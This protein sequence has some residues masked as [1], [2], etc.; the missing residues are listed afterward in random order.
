MKL[1]GVMVLAFVVGA[2]A[3]DEPEETA[4]TPA[5]GTA[6]GTTGTA[7]YS[8]DREF[9]REQL[10]DGE[11]EIELGKLAQ[12]KGTHPEVKQFAEMMVQHHTEAGQNLK[13][14]MSSLPN[15]PSASSE[16]AR[17]TD[18]AEDRRDAREE[19]QNLSGRE[20][21]EKYIDLMVQEHEE[22]VRAVENKSQNNDAHPEIRQWA[23]KTL[24]VLQQ[25][26]ERAK[27][28]KE[29]LDKAGDR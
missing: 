26:L 21:D 3:A 29:T 25:H 6:A 7:D 5:A 24:P 18:A 22:A 14:A 9:I 8:A 4:N 2:C 10:V 15:P 17:E 20:F 13:Q 1:G 12:Q 28:I 23:T 11:A 16:A 27:T 19:L